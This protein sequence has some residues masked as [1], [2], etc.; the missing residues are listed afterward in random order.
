MESS[1]LVWYRWL[2]ILGGSRWKASIRVSALR[3]LTERHCGI[4]QFLCRKPYVGGP[5]IWFSIPAIFKLMYVGL[6]GL[7]LQSSRLVILLSETSL[8]NLKIQEGGRV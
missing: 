7:F 8:R 5:F 1:T 6:A 2:G 4:Y 3:I